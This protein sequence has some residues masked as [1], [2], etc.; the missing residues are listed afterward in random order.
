MKLLD[1]NTS[2]VFHIMELGIDGTGID[3]FCAEAFTA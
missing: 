1:Q 3:G 2:Q